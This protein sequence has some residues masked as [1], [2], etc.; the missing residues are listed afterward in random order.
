MGCGRIFTVRGDSIITL[1]KQTPV[2][3]TNCICVGMLAQSD[4]SIQGAFTAD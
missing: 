1:K 3:I 2:T 4:T